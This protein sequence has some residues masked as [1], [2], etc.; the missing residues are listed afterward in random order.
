MNKGSDLSEGCLWQQRC[1]V[2]KCGEKA[3]C[4][5]ALTTSTVAVFYWRCGRLWF[6]LIIH[7][8]NCITHIFHVL[9]ATLQLNSWCS[10]ANCSPGLIAL[11]LMCISIGGKLIK[12][13][14]IRCG[15]KN[16]IRQRIKIKVW[17]R[18]SW[19]FWCL[20]GKN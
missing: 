9:H 19:V 16:K 1:G 15:L 17:P 14:A 8:C 5:C 2:E 13:I 7:L 3:L 18:N 4:I 6:K 10:C 11:Q 12:L 20:F